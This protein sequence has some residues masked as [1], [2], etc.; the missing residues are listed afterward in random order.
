MSAREPAALA[1][2]DGAEFEELDL[3]MDH[4]D[5][6]LQLRSINEVVGE[7][8]PPGLARRVLNNELNFTSIEE[9]TMFHEAKQ[10]VPWHAVMVKEM[11]AI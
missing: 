10:E 9:P 7:G 11:K 3:D 5:A 8:S 4:D 2:E 1:D 6:P